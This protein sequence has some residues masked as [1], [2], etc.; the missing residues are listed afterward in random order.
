M[1]DIKKHVYQT[2]NSYTITQW[3]KIN[4][5]C[6]NIQCYWANKTTKSRE[7]KDNALYINNLVC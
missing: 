6:Q 5:T 4:Y 2:N 7:N 3:Y 1:P